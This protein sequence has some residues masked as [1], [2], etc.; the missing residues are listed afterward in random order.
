VLHPTASRPKVM[1]RAEF[2]EIWDGGLIL[3]GSQNVVNRMLHALAGMSVPVRDLVRPA[4]NAVMRA[5]DTMMHARDALMGMCFSERSDMP[6]QPARSESEI[7][8]T[9]LESGDESG[10]VAVTIL[11]RC[12]GVAADPEQIRHRMGAARLG[13]TEILRCAKEFGLK[14]RAQKT[15]WSRLAV[16]PLPGIALLRDGGFLILGQVVDDKLMVQ[17]PVSPRPET[18]PQAELEAIWDGDIILMTRRAS[19]TDLSRRFDIGWFVGAVHK[20]RRLLGEVLVASFFL[21]FFAL[22]SPLFSRWS[23]TRCS[24]IEA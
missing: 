19:L 16:T 7:A 20:Y 13:V 12:H 8:S 18:M 23:S 21:Q 1:T 11:L 3:S 5:R 6:V 10:L 15:S 14:A 9:E 22:I 17:R 24:C 4:L 2:E